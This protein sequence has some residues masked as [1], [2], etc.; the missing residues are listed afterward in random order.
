M[1]INANI[2]YG[3]GSMNQSWDLEH[4]NKEPHLI[5]NELEDGRLILIKLDPKKIKVATIQGTNEKQYDYL[6]VI[7]PDNY[8]VQI[9]PKD[10]L[11]D[12]L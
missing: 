8:S 6:E 2:K 12:E 4:L 10:T 1:K 7:S 11:F 9:Y 3:V 5:F